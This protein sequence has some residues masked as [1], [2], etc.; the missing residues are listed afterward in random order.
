M[1]N[2][3]LRY[4]PEFQ[5]EFSKR[6]QYSS[7]IKNLKNDEEKNM[8][9]KILYYNWCP[10]T[11]VEGGGISVY[12]KNLLKYISQYEGSI[13]PYFLCSGFYYDGGPVSVVRQE[14][15]QLGAKVFSIVN[16]P[17]YAPMRAP[18]ENFTAIIEDKTV[19]TIFRELLLNYGP[20]QAVHFQ[21]LEGLPLDILNLKKDFPETK[22]LYSVH[23]YTA[24]CPNV[25]LWTENN[26]N[27]ACTSEKKDCGK[28][29]QR[30]NRPSVWFLKKSRQLLEKDRS[31]LYYYTRGVK[32]VSRKFF[33]IRKNRTQ[34][35]YQ[36]YIGKSIDEINKNM[37]YIL[38][39]S[40]RVKEIV[41]NR[42]IE[43]DKVQVSYIGTQF[44]E[45]AKKT[46]NADPFSDR[47]SI[48]YMGYMRK[49][50]GF[51]FFLDALEQ[52]DEKIANNIDV[53]FATK[54]TD[55][56]AKNR[57]NKLN[58][59]YAGITIYNGYRHEDIDEILNH[60]HLGIVPVLWEDN[61]PQVAVE[62]IAMGVPVLSSSFGG[63][64]ELNSNKA[65]TYNGGD[66]EDF[67]EKLI[68]IYQN[69][70]LLKE[71]WSAAAQLTT[72]KMHFDQLKQFY[73]V[74]DEGNNKK[75]I[76]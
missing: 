14:N 26:S 45:K 44:A 27:C 19:T 6:K 4:Q 58:S 25:M 67:K 36:R 64:S 9:T 38:A 52:L 61:L 17:V 51:Y 32:F 23:N 18:E 16:S 76:S 49:E 29:M 73:G 40:N 68:Y 56:K 53:T 69:R 50:K 70:Y 33:P 8:K 12:Q 10:L 30:Y 20:F 66:I 35:I 47:F 55:Q 3:K 65:F 5:N 48:I 72:M 22:F 42:G 60:K 24:I 57:L 13:E 41:V 63:A 11:E 71:Y 54:I 34:E 28:C 59:R 15:E 74:E 1:Q 37:D 21:T 31:K 43:Q 62:M 46:G 7:Q 75:S 39:V 2:E